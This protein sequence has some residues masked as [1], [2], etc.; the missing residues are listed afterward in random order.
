MNMK[1]YSKYVENK[2]VERNYIGVLQICRR[3][4]M[5]LG[6]GRPLTKQMLLLAATG[7]LGDRVWDPVIVCVTH[8]FIDLRVIR[9][10]SDGTRA[11]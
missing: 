5:V 10:L 8:Y 4:G 2:L 3:R 1:V 11:S 7:S 6:C 9:A